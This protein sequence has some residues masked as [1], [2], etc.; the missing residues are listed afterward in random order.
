MS[1]ALIA[2][3]NRKNTKG[4]AIAWAILEQHQPQTKEDMQNA[5]KDIFAPMFEAMFQGKMAEHLRYGINDHGHKETTNHRNGY[6]HKKV[7]TTYGEI[8]IDREATFKPQ[9]I[10]KR[11]KDIRDIADK[12]LSM[13][14][15]GM[16]QRDIAD[17][18]LQ[19]R[20]I[21]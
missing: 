19:L 9:L 18:Y 10:L 15:K 1:T 7:K 16:S 17:I 2:R 4:A 11:T 8:P 14:K 21:T 13:Y 20:D 3:K 5:I 6:H 12:V